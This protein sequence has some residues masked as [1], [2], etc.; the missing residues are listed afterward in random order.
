MYIICVS[1]LIFSLA[2]NKFKEE[3]GLGNTGAWSGVV[4][5]QTYA[6]II[7]EET[8][9]YEDM[10][11][12]G[13]AVSSDNS[14]TYNDGG[15]SAEHIKNNV[16]KVKN[17]SKNNTKT[18]ASVE[19]QESNQGVVVNSATFMPDTFAG[20]TYV[21]DMSSDINAINYNILENNIETP[22][23]FKGAGIQLQVQVADAT[24]GVEIIVY[25]KGHFDAG[26]I[27]DKV[28]IYIYSGAGISS[29]GNE[30][31]LEAVMFKLNN[32]NVN[33]IASGSASAVLVFGNKYFDNPK[34][35]EGAFLSLGGS[36]G[37]VNGGYAQSYDEYGGIKA[38]AYSLGVSTN[39]K[40][41]G[42]G[43]Y[44]NY[45][46][47]NGKSLDK[48]LK[49]HIEGHMNNIQVF[50]DEIINGESQEHYLNPGGI[51]ID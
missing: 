30:V 9:T 33:K 4:G 7:A 39:S 18:Y 5:N 34:D 40:P 50:L 10:K 47:V 24:V 6:S 48:V 26:V 2:V 51:Y 42:T 17:K 43:N 16:T 29:P 35:Y 27:N 13:Y 1:I 31:I 23:S 21:H 36:G 32:L 22:Y 45:T 15:I 20:N 28:Y 11:N 37:H 44:T 49:E 14:G 41:S 19:A 46:M 8:V 38:R 3:H 25:D 12:D